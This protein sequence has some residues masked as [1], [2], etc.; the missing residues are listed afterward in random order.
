MQEPVFP[1]S[2]EE[3]LATADRLPAGRVRL[4]VI[5][6]AVRVA[7][8]LR[9]VVAGFWIRRQLIDEAA[10]FARWD[11]Y[12]VA[13]A[14]CLAAERND[15][16]RFS[17]ADLLRH[18]QHVIG[19]TVNYPDVSRQ[20]YE[21]LFADVVREFREHGFSLRTVYL[22]RRAAAADFADRDMA[23]AAD[24]EWRKHGRDELSE[25]AEAEMA[26]QM[27]HECFL[28]DDRA[29]VRVA[30]EYLAGPGRAPGIDS[31]LGG[32]A[33]LPLLRLG[34]GTDAA[35]WYRAATAKAAPAAGYFWCQS[36]RLEY[37]GRIGDFSRGVSELEAQLP[38]ALAQPDPLSRYYFLRAASVLLGRMAAAGVRTVAIKAPPG[39]PWG[40][41]HGAHSVS[42]L[43]ELA[44]AEAL[45]IAVQFDRRNGNAYYGEW[46]RRATE[47][48]GRR[49]P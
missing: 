9:D 32:Y 43:D 2:L 35:A 10:Y 46:L 17:G 29:A 26:W 42:E 18:Y 36:F 48:E 20:Q 27:E 3:L 11:L 8:S 19:K 1:D 13:F 44:R 23:L 33:L 28:G 41:G 37:L 38:A 31:W 22:Q 45:A 24:R 25:S 6:Q 15:P 21:S 39:V 34:R 5:E 30:D 16:V 49:A 40:S 7:D 47:P 12:A 14:W 4:E